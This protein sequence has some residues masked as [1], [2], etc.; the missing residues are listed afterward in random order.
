LLPSFECPSNDSFV[1]IRWI[2]Q[3]Y[4]GITRSIDNL[5]LVETEATQAGTA[6]FLHLKNKNLGKWANTD[7]VETMAKSVDDWSA[8]GVQF[9]CNGEAQDKLADWLPQAITYFR[10]GKNKDLIARAEL[11]LESVRF[12]GT[13]VGKFDEEG[14]DLDLR[15]I[16]LF[17]RLIQE[18]MMMEAKRLF[19]RAM[20]LSLFDDFT[21]ERLKHKLAIYF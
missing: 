14:E 13:E 3:L 11:H 19:E 10:N 17:R 21:R 20:E 6:F 7:S 9:A 16:D 1:L 4:T 18:G 8:L 15:A 12:R 5:F 2:L